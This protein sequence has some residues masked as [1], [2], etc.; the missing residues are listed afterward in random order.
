[1]LHLAPEII[2]LLLEHKEEQAKIKSALGAEWVERNNI[3]T[4]HNGDYYTRG[5][6]RHLFNRFLKRHGLP[7]YRVHDTRHACASVM[8]NANI[9]AA[10]VAQILGHATPPKRKGKDLEFM[11]V[12]TVRAILAAVETETNTKLKVAV[13]LLLLL[14]L[15]SGELRGLLWS[16][17][18]IEKGLLYVR[19]SLAEVKGKRY[20]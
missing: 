15:R 12:S 2:A 1:M 20:D 3:V 9:P 5:A 19:H 18:D 16:D 17:I 11:D 10:A 8:I 13:N 6:F 7:H 14:G 4:A